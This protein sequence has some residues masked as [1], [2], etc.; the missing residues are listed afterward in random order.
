MISWLPIDN[1][2]F[3][4]SLENTYILSGL[5]VSCPRIDWRVSSGGT[6]SSEILDATICRKS[7]SR[8]STAFDR[9][10]L[11][12]LSLGLISVGVVCMVVSSGIVQMI[13]RNS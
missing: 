6:T 11:F 1:H 8:L 9:Y 5:T 12:L 7:F 13:P 2:V 4:H 3:V 10:V